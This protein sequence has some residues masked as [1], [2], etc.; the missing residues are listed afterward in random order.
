MGGLV[1]AA[2]KATLCDP[3]DPHLLN[4]DFKAEGDEQLLYCSLCQSKVFSGS[5]HCNACNKCVKGFDHHCMWLNGCIG[6]DNYPYFA[7]SISSVAVMTGIVLVICVYLL[8][9]Y[10]IGDDFEDRFNA[11]S[12][13]SST[14]K[15]VALV[16]MCFLVFMNFPLFLLDLQLVFFHTLLTWNH[17]TTH[18]YI[19][20]RRKM[21][22]STSLSGARLRMES[23]MRCLEWVVFKRRRGKK[24]AQ[25][26]S[27]DLGACGAGGVE[28]EAVPTKNSSEEAPGQDSGAQASGATAKTSA[29]PVR[30][31]DDQD[32]FSVLLVESEH[33]SGRRDETGDADPVA[34]GDIALDSVLGNAPS[35]SGRPV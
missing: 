33:T 4:I 1:V 15:E 34:Q 5:K 32:S 23:A 13:F 17:M 27:M 24:K 8:I 14:P 28:P 2:F 19:M 18:E 11:N 9:D 31:S 35:R 25:V 29:A 26:Q 21:D 6:V 30:S 22:S 20:N 7:V 16:F 3:S 10:F 12:V